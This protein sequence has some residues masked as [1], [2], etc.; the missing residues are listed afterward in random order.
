MMGII[1]GGAK[2]RGIVQKWY[3][4]F[5]ALATWLVQGECRANGVNRPRVHGVCLM[6]H[7]LWAWAFVLQ[8]QWEGHNRRV[9]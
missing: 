8:V 6:A 3:H 5:D 9:F 7:K 1:M 4:T 2:V